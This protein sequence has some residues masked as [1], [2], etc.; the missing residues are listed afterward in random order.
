MTTRPDPATTADVFRDPAPSRRTWRRLVGHLDVLAVVAVG[1]ALGSTGRYLV[2]L[3]LPTP[4]AG[5]PWG[6]L[7]ANVTGCL[8]LGA[9]LVFVLDLWRP[10]RYLRPFLGVGVLGGYTTFSAVTVEALDLVRAGAWPV[11]FGYL[12]GSA[13]VGLLAAWLGV[14]LARTVIRSAQ[15]RRANR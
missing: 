8:A 1:G 15:Q 13:L 10:T 9:L 4:A 2:G 12:A 7:L 11:A 6:T 5:V 14:T 3:A